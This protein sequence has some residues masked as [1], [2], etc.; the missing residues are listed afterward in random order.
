MM[1][2]VFEDISIFTSTQKES[3][4]RHNCSKNNFTKCDD[5]L[6]EVIRHLNKDEDIKTWL[7]VA[8]HLVIERQ[9]SR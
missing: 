4:K 5:C 3:D 1:N 2:L 9:A 6:D 8:W 7:A